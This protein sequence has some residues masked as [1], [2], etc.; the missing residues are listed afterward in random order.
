MKKKMIALT[1]ACTLLLT[2]G[3][4]FYD[5]PRTHATQNNEI[6]PGAHDVRVTISMG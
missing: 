6:I 5:L 1:T 4:A 3:P 2:M